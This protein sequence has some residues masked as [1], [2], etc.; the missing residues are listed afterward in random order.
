MTNQML[1]TEHCFVFNICSKVLFVRNSGI[2]FPILLHVLRA[3]TY[4]WDILNRCVA[5]I[6]IKK[7][8]YVNE[9]TNRAYELNWHSVLLCH[10]LMN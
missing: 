5:G 3:F 8:M 1:R 2:T 10:W 9:I 6:N 7:L 4:P